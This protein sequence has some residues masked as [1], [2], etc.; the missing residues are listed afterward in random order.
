MNFYGF[1][2]GK[3][4]GWWHGYYLGST[5][6]KVLGSDEGIY[7]GST[8]VK[9]LVTIHGNVDVITLGLD[10]GTELVSS[11]RSFDGYNTS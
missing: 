3:L 1:N 10:V 5:D 4:E 11:D 7:L 2:D 9:V 8:G 6:G